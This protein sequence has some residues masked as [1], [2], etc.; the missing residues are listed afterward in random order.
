MRQKLSL[1]FAFVLLIAI[2]VL[3]SFPERSGVRPHVPDMQSRNPSV[4]MADE[5]DIKRFVA[6]IPK[7]AA[8]LVCAFPTE[9]TAVKPYELVSDKLVNFVFGHS[10][11][12]FSE[13]GG[14]FRHG[15]GSNTHENDS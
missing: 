7:T 15:Y 6:T 10:H 9:R 3:D 13:G 1:L 4:W 8:R 12:D 11:F 2:L 5:F 14:T